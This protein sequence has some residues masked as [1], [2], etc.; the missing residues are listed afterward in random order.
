MKH[1]DFILSTCVLSF[2]Y[3][4]V[5]GGWARGVG[6]AVGAVGGYVASELFA[7][8][9]TSKAEHAARDWDMS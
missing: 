3:G 8:W 9:L 7:W 5:F 2:T 1:L 4:A 6:F